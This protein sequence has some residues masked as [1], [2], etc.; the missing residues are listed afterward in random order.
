MRAVWIKT[1]A[2]SQY[3][4]QPFSYVHFNELMTSCVIVEAI[5]DSPILHRAL[6]TGFHPALTS[7]SPPRSTLLSAG[8]DGFVHQWDVSS[9]TLPRNARPMNRPGYLSHILR[10]PHK[11]ERLP[12]IKGLD[13]QVDNDNDTFIVGEWIWAPRR[14]E[15]C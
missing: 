9:G 8:S 11:G 10:S 3:F 1:W 5:C 13:C 14:S 2:H 6:T 4:V 15:T 12:T 7:L